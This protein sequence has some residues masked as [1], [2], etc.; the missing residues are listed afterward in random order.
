[1]GFIFIL[2]I[3]RDMNN[4]LNE[5]FQKHLNLLHKH[6]KENS[7]QL[8]KIDD[9]FDDL[10]K[11][12]K[13]AAAPEA[14]KA[15]VEQTMAIR[16]QL[17]KERD[18]QNFQR[19]KL[20][21]INQ[22]KELR[23]ALGNDEK[24]I[25]AYN[26][27]LNSY[28]SNKETQ[29]DEAEGLKQNLEGLTS[30][31]RG[32]FLELSVEFGNLDVAS[33]FQIDLVMRTDDQRAGLPDSV[34]N[35]IGRGVLS[36]RGLINFIKSLDGRLQG[37]DWVDVEPSKAYLDEFLRFV[38]KILVNASTDRAGGQAEK[39]T[40][41]INNIKKIAKDIINTFTEIQKILN[42]MRVLTEKTKLRLLKNTNLMETMTGSSN[43][44][45]KYPPNIIIPDGKTR[46][47]H[48]ASKVLQNLISNT[49]IPPVFWKR[50][51]LHA[52]ELIKLIDHS[53]PRGDIH[54]K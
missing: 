30:K 49:N 17:R 27:F 41:A 28:V 19:L 29:L 26:E 5:T 3:Y 40:Q 39:V 8:Q 45:N 16:E 2:I 24:L 36:S 53:Q 51:E 23:T 18:L 13:D 4:L 44:I 12:M 38:G 52:T 21:M 31:I 22:I 7:P 33:R 14:A 34:A 6:L 32:D 48:E 46:D 35:L 1:M 20:L 47:G 11:K 9:I 54:I 10:V 43:K 37:Y 25:A 42:T 50:V 15:I